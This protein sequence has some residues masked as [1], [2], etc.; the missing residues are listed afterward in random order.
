MIKNYSQ[1]FFEDPVIQKNIAEYF[2]LNDI[3]GW[4]MG[5]SFQGD[6]LYSR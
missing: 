6:M 4:E 3:S 2:G 1:H 5:I